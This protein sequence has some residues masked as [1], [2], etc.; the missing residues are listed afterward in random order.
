MG[1]T[2]GEGNTGPV[3]LEQVLSPEYLADLQAQSLDDVRRKRLACTAAE[4][5]LSYLRRLAQARLDILRSELARR[6][7]GEGEGSD[8]LVT[9]LAEVLAEKRQ[10]TGPVRLA[11]VL[12]PEVGGSALLEGLDAAADPGAASDPGSLGDEELSDM[13]D[14]LAA[15]EAA[16]SAQRR[17]LH[18]QIDLIHAEIVRRYRDGEAEVGQLLR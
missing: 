17:A 12:V 9:R 10:S 8:D 11:E 2:V 14:R 16:I 3:S 13:A 15:W 18:S 6:S 7:G 1:V 5:Q 4:D